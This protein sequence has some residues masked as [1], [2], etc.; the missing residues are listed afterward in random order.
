MYEEDSKEPRTEK[1]TTPTHWDW[2]HV[3]F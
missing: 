3:F 1:R 2:M